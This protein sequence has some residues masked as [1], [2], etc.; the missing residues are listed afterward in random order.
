VTTVQSYKGLESKAVVLQV[1]RAKT[2]TEL[3]LVYAG[4]TRMKWND[5][6]CYLTIVNS[7][8][9]LRAFSDKA[10]TH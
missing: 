8:P 7:T 5:L 9:E 4:L 2:A 10:E 1:S 3:A 6:G